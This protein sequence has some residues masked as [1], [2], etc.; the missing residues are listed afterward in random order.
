MDFE[1]DGPEGERSMMKLFGGKP[2]DTM[3]WT[4][5][6]GPHRAFRY[7]AR[8]AR[9]GKSVIKLPELPDLEIRIGGAGKQ[10]QSACPPTRTMNDKGEDDPPRLW[11]SRWVIA[12]LPETVFQF[13]DAALSK[14]ESYASKA[15]NAPT[16]TA[17]SPEGEWFRAALRNEAGKVAMAREGDR[18]DT[19]RASARTLGGYLHHNHLEESDVIRELTHAVC[20]AGLEEAEITQT[21]GW[22]LEKGKAEPLPWPEKLERPPNGKPRSGSHLNHAFHAE[23]VE[24][25][26]ETPI[27]LPN[28]PDAARRYGLLRSGWRDRQGD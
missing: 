7:D 28:W 19:L 17:T 3:S 16:L 26:D 20:R 4:S 1:C 18:H 13:L 11:L 5:T 9:Y 6:R 27:V 8:M 23:A 15:W 25:L 12:D 21:I 10:M 22:G 24:E 2:V 14:P